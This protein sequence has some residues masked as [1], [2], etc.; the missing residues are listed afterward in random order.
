[1]AYYEG[2]EY[3]P[4]EVIPYYTNTTA[5]GK[6]KATYSRSYQDV[7]FDMFRHPM[8]RDVG[9]KISSP[10]IKQAI[11]ALLLTSNYERP[12]QPHIGSKINHILFEP[13]N[14]ITE[15]LLADEVKSC[16]MRCEPR[17]Q[18]QEVKVTP[19]YEQNRYVV[20]VIFTRKSIP[21]PESVDV[22]LESNS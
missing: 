3:K 21:D 2:I 10:A 17:A 9:K 4:A 18:I 19:Q 8:S 5:E 1:M 14:P 7:A 6:T 20:R 11:K 13:M 22:V 15:T 16:L 12:Y